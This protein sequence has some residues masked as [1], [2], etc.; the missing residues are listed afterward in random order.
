MESIIKLSELD[1]DPNILVLI[2]HDTAPIELFK[3]SFFPNG[4]I[5]DWQKKG[6]K[7]ATHWHFLNQFPVD[8]KQG[9]DVICDGLYQDGKRIKDLK[10]N[11]V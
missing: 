4:N 11:A 3:D 10:G 2:A 5:N 8:G 6:W 1:A 9:R 7:D